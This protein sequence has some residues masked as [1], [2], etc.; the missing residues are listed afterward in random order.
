VLGSHLV[1]PFVG[2]RRHSAGGGGGRGAQTSRRQAMDSSTPQP[3]AALMAS[4]VQLRTS[5]DN[6]RRFAQSLTAGSRGGV[7][8]W[9]SYV[10]IGRRNQAASNPVAAEA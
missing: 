9:P 10:R 2:G 1:V 4:S 7:R 3:T 6:R 8:L 5:G